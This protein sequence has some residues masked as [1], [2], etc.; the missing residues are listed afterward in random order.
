MISSTSEGGW[1]R[2]RPD[3][4]ALGAPQKQETNIVSA[5]LGNVVSSALENLHYETLEVTLEGDTTSPVNVSIH[6][7]GANPDYLD[8]YP[9]EFNLGIESRLADLLKN[10][11]AVYQIPAEIERRL[12]E[13]SEKK[14]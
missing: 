4:D 2:Y 1:I 12:R 10:A 7:A 5:A 6:V 3:A 14:P 13:L 9:V 11:T 8:G